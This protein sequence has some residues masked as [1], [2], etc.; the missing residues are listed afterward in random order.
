[1]V[2]VDPCKYPDWVGQRYATAGIKY[3]QKNGEDVNVT[4]GVFDEV[5]I[6]NVLQHTMEPDK[7]IRNA[8]A[9]API[10]RI[11]EVIDIPP[12]PGHPHELKAHKLTEWI[13]EGQETVQHGTVEV[14][15]RENALYGTYFYGVFNFS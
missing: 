2:V 11:F 9:V 10:L 4:M 12:C 15:Q 7:I 5:W 14:L 8:R 6:Y 1:M 3:H 13:N